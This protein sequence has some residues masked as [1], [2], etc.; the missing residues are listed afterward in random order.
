MKYHFSYRRKVL[1]FKIE[2]DD[3]YIFARRK[4]NLQRKNEIFDEKNALD[5]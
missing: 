1:Q 5:K 2:S 3:K 4:M